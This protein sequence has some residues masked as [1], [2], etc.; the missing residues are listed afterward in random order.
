M[1]PTVSLVLLISFHELVEV[2]WILPIIFT[3][4]AS[5]AKCP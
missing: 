5:K 3:W 2:E 1:E 4:F